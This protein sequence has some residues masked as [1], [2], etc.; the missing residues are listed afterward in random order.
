MVN[1]EEIVYIK[2]DRNYSVC[3]LKDGNKIMF[4]KTLKA[5][6]NSY[7]EN[8][9]IRIHKSYAVRINC[10][11]SIEKNKIH[12]TDGASIPISRTISKKWLKTLINQNFQ[13]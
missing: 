3:F 13:T 9:I 6:I 12:L 4:A 2:G 8:Q 11:S 10:I 7:N 5:F 1:C